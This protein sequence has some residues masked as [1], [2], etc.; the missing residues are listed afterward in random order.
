MRFY[1]DK[2]QIVS[3]QTEL[4][5]LFKMWKWKDFSSVSDHAFIKRS[6]TNITNILLKKIQKITNY[7]YYKIKQNVKK[8]LTL[9]LSVNIHFAQNAQQP[10]SEFCKLQMYYNMNKM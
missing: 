10:M 7:T 2:Q 9:F 5:I 4:P 3:V 8:L 6:V 1:A